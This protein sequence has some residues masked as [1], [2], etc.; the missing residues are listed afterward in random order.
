MGSLSVSNPNAGGVGKIAFFDRSRSLWL[1][2]LT[3]N[4]SKWSLTTT[5]HW[6]RNTWCHQQCW[7]L[8]QLVY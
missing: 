3:V 2:R 8:S 6:Q 5:M 1:R 4:L 7:W